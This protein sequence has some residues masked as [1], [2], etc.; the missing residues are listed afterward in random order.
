VEA[1]A[2]ANW[3]GRFTSSGGGCKG[4]KIGGATAALLID[5]L[6]M[7]AALGPYTEQGVEISDAR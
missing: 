5:E 7:L 4:L 6:P 2:T 3:W 1:G